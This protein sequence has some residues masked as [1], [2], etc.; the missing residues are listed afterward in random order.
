VAT[1]T[2]TKR[3]APDVVSSEFVPEIVDT[4]ESHSESSSIEAGAS[5]RGRPRKWASEADRKRAYR[6]RLAADLA[7][8]VSLRRELRDEQRRSRTLEARVERLTAEL[9]RKQAELDA[10]QDRERD[11]A[12]VTEYLQARVQH[13]SEQLNAREQDG[14]PQ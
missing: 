9:S 1:Q 5:R 2:I 10:V 6:E 7:E 11:L 4:N 3:C 12:D 8:P 14:D 13:L